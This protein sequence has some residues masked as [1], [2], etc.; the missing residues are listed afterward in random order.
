MFHLVSRKFAV[1]K[2]AVGKMP[3]EF[4]PQEISPIGERQC[5]P[6]G[7]ARYVNVRGSVQWKGEYKVGVDTGDAKFDCGEIS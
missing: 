3:Q 2:F 4:S 5:T 6:K 7:Q 1:N